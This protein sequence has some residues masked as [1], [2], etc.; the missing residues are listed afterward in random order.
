VT[1][2]DYRYMAEEIR[3]LIP[4][5]VHRQAIADLRLLADRYEKLAQYLE[6]APGKL[7]DMSLKARRH[8]G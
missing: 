3:D 8:A 4:L 1:N 2:A 6:T 7:P 5:L